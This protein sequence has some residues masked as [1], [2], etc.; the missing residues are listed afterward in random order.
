MPTAGKAFYHVARRCALHN[1]DRSAAPASGSI[2]KMES[3]T[4]P[5]SEY[6]GP[7]TAAK[8]NPNLLGNALKRI[9]WTYDS[10]PTWAQGDA[11]DAWVD[12]EWVPGVIA[13][14]KGTTVYI[15]PFLVQPMGAGPE[16]SGESHNS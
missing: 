2:N 4:Q 14:L 16:G 5:R 9:R 15:N 3:P 13:R 10:V 12:G 6:V 8:G 7:Y 1:T 11:V